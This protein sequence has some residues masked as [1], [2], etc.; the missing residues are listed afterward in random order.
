MEKEVSNFVFSLDGQFPC[1]SWSQLQFLLT[2]FFILERN[3]ALSH[4][5]FAVSHHILLLLP[6]ICGVEDVLC[7]CTSKL[8]MQSILS[9]SV[10]RIRLKLCW[11]FYERCIHWLRCEIQDFLH[12]RLPWLRGRVELH[13]GQVTKTCKTKTDIFPLTNL[14]V[15]N[16]KICM[17]VT[18]IKET[19]VQ[20]CIIVYQD[21]LDFLS[22]CKLLHLQIIFKMLM[23]SCWFWLLMASKIITKLWS[24][25]CFES[26]PSWI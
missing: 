15:T 11:D 13:S 3:F 20:A 7:C 14:K 24:L 21:A 6:T 4:R 10:M 9:N 12:S 17:K 1:N 8:T 5:H 26:I 18:T 16:V 2:F 23:V 22:F 19:A 25:K